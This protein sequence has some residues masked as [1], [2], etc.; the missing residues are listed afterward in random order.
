M[1]YSTFVQTVG[2]AEEGLIKHLTDQLSQPLGTKVGAF[3]SGLVDAAASVRASWKVRSALQEIRLAK[4]SD[5]SYRD[6]YRSVLALEPTV[7]Q[8]C[9]ACDTPLTGDRSVI[10]NPYVKA[11]IALSGLTELD[12]LESRI[13]IST[14]QLEMRASG[15][16]SQLMHLERHLSE[17]ELQNTDVVTLHEAVIAGG[18]EIAG[19]WWQDLIGL[20]D[21]PAT[22]G[23]GF[24]LSCLERIEN[25]DALLSEEEARRDGVR[26]EL[27]RLTSFR[28][29][30]VE[31]ETQKG[32]L[33]RR[34]REAEDSLQNAEAA[35]S[36]AQDKAD[37]E[38]SAN[39]V[40]RRITSAYSRLISRLQRYRENLPESLLR[41]LGQNVIALYNAFNR[42]D[43][44]GDLMSDIRLPLKSGDRIVFS[45]V[46]APQE[47]FDALH[48]LSEGHIRCLGLAILLA[49]N[50]QTD[51]PVLIF[52]DPVNAIDDD[53]REGIRLTLF[54][55]PF[56]AGKQII[57]TCHGEEFTKDIQNLLGVADAKKCKGYT[58]LPHS[59]DRQ[60]R[61]QVIPTKNHILS[62][63][64][65]LG[66]NELRGS[67]TD[68]RRGLEWVANT[69]WT[70]VLPNS[71]VRGLSV[72]LARRGTRPELF[73][74]VQSLVKEM[75]K[76]SF[77]N[78]QKGKL[79]SGLNLILGLNQNGKEWEYLNKGTH[80]EEDRT[81][82]DRDVVATVVEALESL[83]AAITASTQQPVLLTRTE[84][85]A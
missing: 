70:K 66:T 59:G 6:L 67:L 72:M 38:A 43:P 45:Y 21:E 18:T 65:K 47:Y 22:L 19:D 79:I 40:R 50:L 44:E 81:E 48:V 39:G 24:L 15:L 3:R 80:E 75:S 11:R 54:K 34:I 26:K 32:E 12:E 29:K 78:P 60:I 61:V 52:D 1:A 73:N 13:E 7:P 46:S 8:I 17:R 53:H 74:L 71:G 69:I 42:R 2:N 83:D 76:T 16:L 51:C 14:R 57:L 58:F 56:F 5:L 20:N 23:M 28:E 25:Q 4:A 37:A 10:A 84:L 82:F 85:S 41:D 62:A 49:K 63:R 36:A 64:N 55:D 68:A 27:N 31:H 9:P 30:I 35:I 77:T 33:K